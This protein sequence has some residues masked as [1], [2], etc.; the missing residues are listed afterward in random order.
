MNG[1]FGTL[2]RWTRKGTGFFLGVALCGFLSASPA[3]AA[4]LDV[5]GPPPPAVPS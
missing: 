5:F 4:E 3:P 2:G 1:I